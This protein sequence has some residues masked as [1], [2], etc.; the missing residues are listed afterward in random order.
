MNKNGKLK[1]I[2]KKWNKE[3][4]NKL[5]KNV[6]EI[7]EVYFLPEE[8]KD[9][10]NKDLEN[11]LY[12]FEDK[13]ISNNNLESIIPDSE[14]FV[15]RKEAFNELNFKNELISTDAEFKESK[16]IVDLGDHNYYFYYINTIN[17]LCEGY[18]QSPKREKDEEIMNKF[19]VLSPEKFRMFILKENKPDIK[20][21]KIF[22]NLNKYRIVFKNDKELIKKLKMGHYNEKQNISKTEKIWGNTQRKGKKQNIN[23]EY[24]EEDKK[25]KDLVIRCIIYYYFTKVDINDLIMEKDKKEYNFILI[26][27]EWIKL[28]KEEYNYNFYER[29]I[30]INKIDDKNY[31]QYMNIF[32]DINIG[33]IKPI[34]SLN[35]IKINSMNT[36][37]KIYNNYELINPE[38]YDLLIEYFGKETN[39][40][41]I[42]LNAIFFEYNYYLIKYN[43]SMFEVI[44]T[45]NES[46]RFLLIGKT[47][48][49]EIE[50]DILN[51]GFIKWI[52][53][54]N[55]TEY[56]VASL[57]IS[58]IKKKIIQK[59]KYVKE[60]GI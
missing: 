16:L 22:Y 57:E 56:K 15:M 17:D 10:N 9:E 50:D 29:K 30:K 2:I 44:K 27:S 38:A 24:N 20:D 18:I 41:I 42:E 21:N 55:F 11:K 35:E 32:K 40:K 53:K 46:E 33:K 8:W 5:N 28:F 26:D 14:F 25:N 52:K 12:N 58:K 54:N 1:E 23:N 51:E 19:K 39:H 3:L 37:Y 13:K 43:S 7:I 60:K 6:N 34:P 4:I 47:R 49:D 36:E 48:I 31:F 59:I 45:K